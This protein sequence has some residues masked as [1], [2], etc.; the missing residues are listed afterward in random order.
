MTS[1]VLV[2]IENFMPSLFIYMNQ[3][4][5]SIFSDIMCNGISRKKFPYSK[6]EYQ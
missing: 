2:N 5:S 6:R 4:T 3:I 1:F